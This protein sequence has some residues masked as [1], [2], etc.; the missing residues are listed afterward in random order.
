MGCEEFLDLLRS[1]EIAF[2][3][4][5]YICGYFRVVLGHYHGEQRVQEVRTFAEAVEWLANS[6]VDRL[7]AGLIRVKTRPRAEVPVSGHKAAD[8]VHSKSSPLG[9][10]AFAAPT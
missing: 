9:D 7:P 3:I 2:E 5:T 4:N 10:A 6:C 8:V 1:E